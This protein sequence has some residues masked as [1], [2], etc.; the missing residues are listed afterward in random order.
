MCP[1]HLHRFETELLARGPFT[2]LRV[3]VIPDG[4]IHR[5]RAWGEA[6]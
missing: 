4:G 2:H 1:D 3:D 6:V 5:I